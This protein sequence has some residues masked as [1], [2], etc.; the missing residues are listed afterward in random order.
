MKRFTLMV[1]PL[2]LAGATAFGDES[3]PQAT[4]TDA[5]LMKACMEKQKSNSN[6]TLS[7][8]QLKRYCRDQLKQQKA[9]GAM[10]ENPPE[11]VPKDVTPHG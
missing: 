10:P 4:P 2:I 7:D 9:T 11:D 1:L 8:A 6:V 5:Q 3:L